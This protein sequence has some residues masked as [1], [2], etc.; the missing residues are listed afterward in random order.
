VPF[1]TDERRLWPILAGSFR[2]NLTAAG[3]PSALTTVAIPAMNP[4]APRSTL[5]LPLEHAGW[6]FV[7]PI[8]SYKSRHYFEDNNASF[9]Y[10]LRQHGYGVANLRVGWRS[11][12]GRWEVTAHADNIFDD[13]H[14]IDAGNTGGSFGIPT[15][16]AG[17]P[18]RIGLQ[19]S[20]R[21]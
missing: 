18:R 13:H 4:F 6:F 10:G 11:P 9:N 20:V 15:F 1:Y 12:K 2:D 7:T 3:V 19:A 16:I 21:W 17:D 8:Y 14:L 5:P